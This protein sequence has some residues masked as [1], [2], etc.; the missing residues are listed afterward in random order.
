M[1]SPR[2]L[3]GTAIALAGMLFLQVAIALAAC[4][5]PDRAAAL[6][7]VAAM[8]SMPDCQGAGQA[9]LGL[10]HCASEQP[11]LVT[12]QTELPVLALPPVVP[13][14]LVLAHAVVLPNLRAALPPAAGPPPRILFQTFL[15]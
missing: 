11:A 6:A 10:A 4:N 14:T 9:S 7:S 3:A 12:A 13:P 15:L 1:M 8:A 2:R 5:L